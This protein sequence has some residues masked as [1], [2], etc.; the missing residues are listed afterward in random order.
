MARPVQG[1]RQGLACG[2]KLLVHFAKHSRWAWMPGLEHIVKQLSIS[3]PATESR[4]L[5]DP[6]FHDTDV[7]CYSHGVGS[8]VSGQG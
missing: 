7:K 4:T 8:I 1:R 3:K 5:T 6:F 2:R